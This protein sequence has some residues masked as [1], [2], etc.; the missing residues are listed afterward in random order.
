MNRVER[1]RFRVPRNV[2]SRHD[3]LPSRVT[4]K[5]LT[6][7]SV[8]LYWIDYSGRPVFYAELNPVNR[9]DPGFLC[10][11]FV[12]HPWV[13]VLPRRRTQ[14]L[15]NGKFYFF[16]PDQQHWMYK[17]NGWMSSKWNLLLPRGDD[18]IGVVVENDQEKQ[19]IATENNDQHFEALISL[20]GT[21]P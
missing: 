9:V 14:A 2:K 18:Y 19:E 6:D 16:P 10:Q 3:R 20:P 13:A 5:N 7:D 1:P 11:T 21:S 8:L 4:F 17:R 12:S 15:L